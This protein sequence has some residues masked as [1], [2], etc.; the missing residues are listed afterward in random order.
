MDEVIL[1]TGASSELALPLVQR[2]QRERS[3]AQLHL[4]GGLSR[5]PFKNSHTYQGD[6]STEAGSRALVDQLRDHRFTH[7]I[8]MH[9][10]GF[11]EDSLLDA[12]ANSMR[13][14]HTLNLGSNIELVRLVLPGM[15]E[16]SFGRIVFLS[17]ASAAR[18]GGKNS[19]SYGLAKSGLEYTTRHLARFYT[20]QDILTNTVAPGFIRT[21][22][23]KR[24]M[25]RTAEQLA[26][27]EKMVP[28]GRAGEPKD[29]ANLVYALAFENN[30][31]SG[32]IISVDA[33]DFV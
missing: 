20:W 10:A 23:H 25:S 1:V 2:I 32:Q 9:G 31:T 14:T 22:F 27:R 11:P 16:N 6:L 15:Q 26:E 19:F 3:N 4:V 12:E 7:F 5:P 33:A 17:T 13:Q 18:G 30:F 21:R 8:S 29:V 28:L 24:W